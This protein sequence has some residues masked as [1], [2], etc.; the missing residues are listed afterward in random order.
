MRTEAEM[1][2][3]KHQI[4]MNLLASRHTNE[5]NTSLRETKRR[6]D[7]TYLTVAQRQLADGLDEHELK[8]LEIKKYGQ[9]LDRLYRK[10]L[11]HKEIL[12]GIFTDSKQIAKSIEANRLLNRF[13]DETG[14][15]EDRKL[16][17]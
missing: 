13:F 3:D 11:A 10:P 12:K 9:L 6:G 4:A 7:K 15:Q 17:I 14:V 2:K 1:K 5:D 16:R 8:D